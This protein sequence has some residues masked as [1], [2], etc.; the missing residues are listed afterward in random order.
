MNHFRALIAP[1]ALDLKLVKRVAF[2]E[3]CFS[4]CS[5]N[6]LSRSPSASTTESI[7]AATGSSKSASGTDSSPGVTSRSET[8]SCRRPPQSFFSV[9]AGE[10]L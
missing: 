9:L 7:T 1:E 10:D 8:V 2:E 4:I 3:R 6:S 5:R